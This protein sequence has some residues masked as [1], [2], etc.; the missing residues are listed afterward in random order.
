MCC[1]EQ[2]PY[3]K[4]F[5]SHDCYI[6]LNKFKVLFYFIYFNWRII[7]CKLI[8]KRWYYFEV[9]NDNVEGSTSKT[10]TLIIN[11]LF[12][13][14]YYKS[15]FRYFCLNRDNESSRKILHL[16]NIRR[17]Y[18]LKFLGIFFKSKKKITTILDTL[19]CLSILGG[20]TN[21]Q[22]GESDV[23]AIIITVHILFNSIL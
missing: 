1:K 23:L 9:W 6:T 20:Y 22:Q 10:Y 18:I 2:I 13:G 4:I 7:G 15:L 3:V 11:Y 21:Y 16:A 8:A 14:V 12:I 5:T 19:S 17:I